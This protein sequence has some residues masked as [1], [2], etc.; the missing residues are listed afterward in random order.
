MF[1]VDVGVNS[2]PIKSNFTVEL[3]HRK[4]KPHTK[5]Y[6]VEPLYNGHPG[7]KAFIHPLPHSHTKSPQASWSAAGRRKRDFLI[8]CMFHKVSPTMIFKLTSVCYA[9]VLLMI[10]F[11]ITLSN[12]VTVTDNVMT[13]IYHH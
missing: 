7:D 13:K 10:N 9:S 5:M 11:V 1:F 3:L 2:N 12:I 6:T 4:T 8:S